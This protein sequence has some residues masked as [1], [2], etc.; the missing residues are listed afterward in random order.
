MTPNHCELKSYTQ[1][2]ITIFCSPSVNEFWSIP[3]QSPRPGFNLKGSFNE[4][5]KQIDI[6]IIFDKTLL[7][8]FNKSE[9]RSIMVP[10]TTLQFI[11]FGFRIYMRNQIMFLVKYQQKVPVNGGS[12]GRNGF[13]SEMNKQL[14]Y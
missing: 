8:L 3:K 12:K 10:I 4:T 5:R 1:N 6:V 11:W 7:S 2:A 9:L 14:F 13:I